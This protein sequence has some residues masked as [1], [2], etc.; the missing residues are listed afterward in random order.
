MPRSTPSLFV[1]SVLAAVLTLAACTGDPSSDGEDPATGLPDD[2]T[3]PDEGSTGGGATDDGDTDAAACRHDDLE[4]EAIVTLAGDDPVGVGSEVAVRT[5]RC[6]PIA[7]V[8][9]SGGWAALL[10]VP[11]ARAMDAP[12]LLVDPTAPAALTGTLDALDVDELVA[13]GLPLDGLDRPGTALVAEASGTTTGPTDAE[14]ATAAEDATE[15]DL[16][17]DDTTADDATEEDPAADE[18]TADDTTADDA[19]D[20][21][22]DGDAAAAARL[23]VQVAEHLDVERFLAV[24]HGDAHARLAAAYRTDGTTGLLPVPDDEAALAELAASLPATARLTAIAS[25]DAEELAERLRAAG[26]D[27]D[28]ATDALWPSEPGPT[29]WLADPEQADVAAVAAVAAAG[30]GEALLPIAAADLR[31]GDDAR[32]LREVAP[33]RVVLVGDVTEDADWQLETVLTGPTLPGGGHRLFENERMVAIYGHPGSTVLGALG[34][35]DLDGAVERVREVAAPYDADG[36]EVLPTFEI[37]TT[38]ASAE[39]GPRG[40]YSR[41]TDPDVLRPWIDRAAEE[42]FY[43]VLDL[44]PGRTDFLEQAQEYEDLLREPHVG[45]ALD[46]EWRLEPDQVHLRQIGSVQAEEVQRVADWLAALTREHRL[47]QK[48]LVLHQ[49]RL[50]MLPDRDTIVTPPELAIVVHMDGQGAIEDKYATYDLI[51]TGAEDRWVW[52]W[53]NFYDEDIPTPTPEEVLA[54]EPLPWFVTYQ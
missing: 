20:D 15:E 1:A 30:R 32:R 12:L 36:A 33:E 48:A 4:D 47:P 26:L 5:H 11:V 16:A 38:I 19:A 23:A 29:G 6:A 40:D 53:K 54:V 17:A 10:A 44:Q 25:D 9:P 3:R 43:V 46:P 27:A 14:D 39:A 35:Q 28:A 22:A 49:F 2:E 37:I 42:G 8:A 21:A 18:A 13:V 31:A 24:R 7:V 45:L 51:T 50:A 34:E 52:G 41:R